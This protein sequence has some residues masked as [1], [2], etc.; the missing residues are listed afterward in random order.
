MTTLIAEAALRQM[1]DTIIQAGGSTSAEAEI[2]T[3]HLV[4]ANLT[5]HDSHGVGMLQHYG[6]NIKNGTLVPNTAAELVSDQGAI[7][8]YDGHRG[9]GQRVGKEAMEAAI[10]RTRD[11]GLTLM[12]IRNSAHLG[13]IGTYGEMAADAGLVS[14]HFVNVQDHVALVAPFRGSDP[15]FGTN[16]L[17]IAVPA[18]AGYPRT[19]VDMATSKIAM[20]K[21]RVAYNAGY[22]VS[23][24][25]LID[26]RGQPTNDPSVMWEEPKGAL[27]TLA[28]HKGY[29]LA[30]MCELL[31]GCLSGGGTIQPGNER[32]GGIINCMTTFL[33]DPGRLADID[34][35]KREVDATF[36]YFTA[37]PPADPNEPVL[38]PGDPE[39]ARMAER[40]ANGIPIDD[41]TWAKVLAAGELLGLTRGALEKMAA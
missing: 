30:M 25:C 21:T 5:G 10:A 11:T 12:T 34:W 37:S 33:I 29:C 36:D 40:Q 15:R 1:T 16:P 8:Q 24:G 32:K 18:T 17:C 22:E 14:M 39:R 4:R 27:R 35:I 7:L 38:I 13:R 20:G 41:G 23:D 2:V 9:Y 31:A 26:H 28:E 3:D 6:E 19:I